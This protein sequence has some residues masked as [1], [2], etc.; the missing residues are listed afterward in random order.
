MADNVGSKVSFFLVGLGI[1]ALLGI[2]FAPKSGEETR[3]YLSSKAD[4]GRDF[5]Q[6]KARELRERAEDLIERSKEI[7]ARQKESLAAAVDAGKEAFARE[8]SKAS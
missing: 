7:M 6:K 3:E 4:E 8:K 2:L 5:A 1:G